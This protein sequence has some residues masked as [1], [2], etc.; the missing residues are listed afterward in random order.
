MKKK[1]IDFILSMEDKVVIRGNA[2][3]KK[4]IF[5]GGLALI[6]YFVILLV[7]L[8]FSKTPIFGEKRNAQYKKVVSKE[9]EK[10]LT[11]S[12]LFVE[13]P[14]EKEDSYEKNIQKF[15]NIPNEEI[16]KI[17]KE[18]NLN[19]S[20]AEIENFRKEFLKNMPK[21][22][23]EAEEKI[24]NLKD[25]ETKTLKVIHKKSKEMSEE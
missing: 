6:I 23:F 17:F 13:E 11:R 3:P 25:L 14:E 15:A 7:N 20:D 8:N 22:Q 12:E 16:K 9:E 5:M 10:N 24:K 21:N 1:I 19:I 18:Q 4:Y 2:I